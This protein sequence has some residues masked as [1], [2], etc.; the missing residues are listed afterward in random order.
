MDV[1]ESDED[2]KIDAEI[3]AQGRGKRITPAQRLEIIH[4]SKMNWSQERIKRSLGVSRRTVKLWIDRYRDELNVTP[5]LKKM[6]DL[7]KQTNMKTFCYVA[8]VSF[9]QFF[10]LSNICVRMNL[11]ILFLI[12][13]ENN[14]DNS[15]DV[16]FKAGID[17]VHISTI[18]RRL[19]DTGTISNIAAVKDILTGDHLAGRLAFARRY[20]SISQ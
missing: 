17:N 4:L 8:P 14:F 19:I 20:V 10:H 11:N 13:I 5:Q 15:A 2:I 18:N 12:A 1:H 9:F 6:E 3:L 7:E 16:A